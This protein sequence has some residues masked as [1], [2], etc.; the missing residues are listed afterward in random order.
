MAFT[1]A[2]PTPRPRPDKIDNMIP[3]S[4]TQLLITLVLIVPGFVFLG[5]LVRLRGRTPADADLSSRLMRAIVASTVFALVYLAIAGPQIEA[6]ANQNP[7]EALNHLQK[8]ALLALLAAF[9]IPAVAAGLYYW[10][11]TWGWLQDKFRDSWVDQRWNRIDPRPSGWDVAFADLSPC[12]VRVR[13]NDGGWYA[14]WFGKASYASSWPD[15]RSLYV[16]VSFHVDDNGTLGQAV[17][18]SNGAVI[19]CTDAVL[20]ELLLPGPDSDE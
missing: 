19:D 7:D 13:M 12:F 18:N 4:A 3:S 20:V 17:E 2:W 8:Y 1:E 5:V 15:P 11:S 9:V 16:E 14:G 6:L 10:I